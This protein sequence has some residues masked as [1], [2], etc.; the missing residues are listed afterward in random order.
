M[1]FNLFIVSF[2]LDSL[3]QEEL[4]KVI[5]EDIKKSLNEVKKYD[6]VEE[7]AIIQ[8]CNCV[9]LLVISLYGYSENKFEIFNF[10]ER[11]A[12]DFNK[13]YIEK[14]K[15]R[16]NENAIMHFV[17][18]ICG[19]KSVLVGD[20]QV[21]GQIRKCFKIAKEEGS[22][23]EVLKGL[24]SESRKIYNQVKKRTDLHSG[25]ISLGREAVNILEK[26]GSEKKI[27]LFG[28]GKIAEVVTSALKEEG[29]K[30]VTIS[31]RT[32]A[33]AKKL[34]SKY[35]FDY[36]SLEEGLEMSRSQEIIIFAT[37]RKGLFDLGKRR[38]GEGCIIVDLGNPQNVV[39]SQEGV[40]ILNVTDIE[41]R[42]NRNFKKRVKES[43][44]ALRII[45]EK[46][47]EVKEKLMEKM[48][49]KKISANITKVKEM[50]GKKKSKAILR[51]RSNI[52]NYFRDFLRKKGFIEVHF[53]S[54]NIVATDPVSSGGEL[55]EVNW[56]NRKA[57][58]AQSVQLHKQM[59]I[60]SGLE[61]IFSI[62]PFWRAQED[63]T[64]R[65]NSEAWSLDIE[66]KIKN[67]KEIIFLLKGLIRHVINKSRKEDRELLDLFDFCLESSKVEFSEI[68]YDEAVNE[69]KKAGVE[70]EYGED[71]GYSKELELFKLLKNKGY[72][73]F[74]FIY[75][76]PDNV[77][78]F[79]TKG[80]KK[81][82]TKTF[83][84]MFKGWE[85]IS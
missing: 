2:S 82:L 71:L 25:N 1:K 20:N 69:L 34:A 62:S 18:T 24:F 15:V 76:Y 30:K 67:V 10:W 33:K 23:G 78:K 75:D 70:I 9:E 32:A 37:S 31:N 19:L 51:L 53:P 85:I 11:E 29:F 60:L 63:R 43:K 35:D 84:L 65:H 16:K 56:Y 59:L 41:K 81:N 27:L 5:F 40:E 68:T 74:I 66:M 28:A 77:K 45:R 7:A 57:Y 50:L 54:V 39:N 22:S 80:K 79:Y 44:K 64:P 8:K 83:D 73:D 14:C 58:L 36:C 21:A 3:S 4:G 48:N 42:N 61:K 26:E 49:S 52:F 38:L 72:K 12:V 13:K 46:Q 6:F 47:R 55:F 17:K